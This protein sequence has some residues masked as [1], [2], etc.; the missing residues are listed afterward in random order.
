MG[1]DAGGDDFGEATGAGDFGLG[2]AMVGEV[3]GVVT[4]GDVVGAD[5]GDWPPTPATTM[6]INAK[7]RMLLRSICNV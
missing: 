2:G 7:E 5:A 4:A 6:Q 3:E 1:E